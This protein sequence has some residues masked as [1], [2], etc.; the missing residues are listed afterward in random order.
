VRPKDL[1][2]TI[3]RYDVI[4]RLGH[5]GM[6]VVYR[7]RDP[8]IGRPV[9]IKLLR[10][11]DE[12]QRSRFLQEAQS[13][14]NLKH[15]NIV[16]IYDYGEHEE[17]PYIV[18]EYIEG[19][20][21]A[22]YIRQNILLELPRKLALIE[23]LSV[24]LDY[25]HN[26]GV[27][28]RDIKPANIMVDGEGDLKILDFGIARLGDSSLTQAGV[29]IG[30]PNYMSPEQ[31]DGRLVDRRSDI[32]AVGLVFYELLTYRQAFPGQTAIAVM[33]AIL[34]TTP[35]FEMSPRIHPGLQTIVEKAIEKD[36]ARR[37]QTLSALAADIALFRTRAGASLEAQTHEDQPTIQLRAP[38]PTPE[39]G[40]R[41]GHETH[42]STPTERRTQTGPD[43]ERLARLRAEKLDAHL[44][45]AQQAFN[46]SD[47]GHAVEACEQAALIDPDDH[48]VVDLLVRAQDALTAQ[49]VHQWL[50]QARVYLSQQNMAG[51]AELVANALQ[52]APSSGEARQLQAEIEAYIRRV[53]REKEERQAIQAALTRARTSLA[54]GDLDSAIRNASEVLVR[55]PTNSDAHD[56]NRQASAAADERRRRE[57]WERAAQAGIVE[58]RQA[59]ADGRRAEAIAAL[60]RFAPPHE[61]VTAALAEMRA[62]LARIEQEAREEE[63]RR[64]AQQRYMAGQ[65][66]LARGHMS[67]GRFAEAIAGLERVERTSPEFPG[68]A[69]LL[70]DART[71]QAAAQAEAERQKKAAEALARADQ[72]LAANRLDD[73]LA[74]VELALA[75]APDHRGALAKHG[76]VQSKIDE[77]RRKDEFD[78]QAETVVDT[79][80]RQF[81]AGEHAAAL[82]RLEPFLAHP[83]AARLRDELKLKLAEIERVARQSRI[84]D[85]RRKARTEIN[86]GKFAQA[87]ERLRNVERVEGPAPELTELVELARTGQVVADEQAR[88]EREIQSLL[89][90][91]RRRVEKKD[92][93]GAAKRIEKASGIDPSHKG[94]AE[95]LA[96]LES[97][98]ADVRRAEDARRAEEA[99]RKAEEARKRAEEARKREEER[100]RKEAEAARRRAVAAE[101]AN[102]KAANVKAATVKAETE[103]AEVA[104][105]KTPTAVARPSIDW[106]V[107]GALAAAALLVAF[108]GYRIFN[109]SS[110]SITTTSTEAPTSI[111]ST[112]SIQPTSVASTVPAGPAPEVVAGRA[113]LNRGELSD[114]ARAVSVALN[115][116]PQDPDLIRLSQQILD[117]AA[118]RADDAKR[119]ADRANASSRPEYAAA[120]GHVRSASNLKTAGRVPAAVDEYQVAERL[121]SEAAQVPV[122][123]ASVTTTAITTTAV[124]PTTIRSTTTTSAPV[125]VQTT[126]IA[127]TIVATVD[128]QTIEELLNRFAEASREFDLGAI[129]RVHPRLTE[130]EK[131]RLEALT[132][133]YSYC[134]Y[135]FTNIQTVSSSATEAVVRAE[136]GEICKPRT[137]QRPI[138][139]PTL[140]YQFRLLKNSSGSWIID[141]ILTSQ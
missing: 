24:A 29:M 102:V 97:A 123:V 56:L 1:P 78:R 121:Y 104:R 6:G 95:A 91:A 120:A 141:E 14:G 137:R 98:Q 96:L 76:D 72:A 69:Q 139:N 42:P 99:K 46:A 3:G 51:A 7:G 101:A 74:A 71:G 118:S 32:F 17:Q 125:Q 88:I 33:H 43:R 25:A 23:E 115:R 59:F 100:V 90:E 38:T 84:E 135:K 13:A 53:R 87:L 54:N 63:E 41:Y 22:T 92:F 70:Q 134:E 116:T 11:T 16:T 136:S 93:S 109:G 12:S 49:Q 2:L 20:T 27:V 94:V 26:K 30:T 36:P 82:A 67:A 57:A 113:L 105:A 40:L 122:T 103:R 19:V 35:S 60:E 75:W 126:S 28:H 44:D 64:R 138:P 119:T 129:Q 130:R 83:A 31:I 55:D 73:A 133:N 48:R 124:A 62:E 4:D 10:V 52:A 68:L 47:F 50:E 45:T 114:A 9:A 37:Y 127:S 140:Q 81:E 18:M 61:A 79:A 39:G 108:V 111:A 85:E 110:G 58:Q 80:R 107:G 15:P 65:L 128:R 77:K 132:R 112:T 131:L 66:E 86:A 106:K 89:T 34:H 117:A 21:F 8:R 5:G